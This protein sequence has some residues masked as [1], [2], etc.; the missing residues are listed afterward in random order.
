MKIFNLLL[1]IFTYFAASVV[2]SR[3]T[4]EWTDLF[5]GFIGMLQDANVG[6]TDANMVEMAEL[7]AIWSEFEFKY[8]EVIL[9]FMKVHLKI[10]F[11]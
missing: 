6:Y 7:R 11:I 8:L 2:S 9:N 10:I 4:K 5:E 1:F 3:D